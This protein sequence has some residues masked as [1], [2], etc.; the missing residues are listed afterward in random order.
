[1]DMTTIEGWHGGWGNFQAIDATHL[2]S[3]EGD[4]QGW[5]FYLSENRQGGEFFAKYSYFSN[6]SG[7]L[8]HVRLVIQKHELFDADLELIRYAEYKKRISEIGK[9]PAADELLSNGFK[10]IKLWEGDNEHH[11]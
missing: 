1:M 11:G 7:F 4:S 8:H 2:G 10:V 5:G 3:G 6:G 9:K